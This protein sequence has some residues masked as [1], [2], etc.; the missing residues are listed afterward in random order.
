MKP[1]R[2]IESN[3]VYSL[4][5]GTEDNDLWAEQATDQYGN[6]VVCSVWVPTEAERRMIAEGHNIELRIFGG[7]P[8]VAMVVTDVPLGRPAVAE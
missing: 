1:R 3:C 7:Q 6:L 2:T 8:P 5:G 4:E